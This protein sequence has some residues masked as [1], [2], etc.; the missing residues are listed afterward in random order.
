MSIHL[1]FRAVAGGEIRDDHAWLAEFMWA[2]WKVHAEEYAAGV[3]DSIDKA[4]DS[5]NEL[6]TAAE[7]L[8]VEG[9]EPWRLP[10][11]GGRPVRYGGGAERYDPPLMVMDAADVSRA[12]EFLA[13]VSF[14]ELWSVAGTR[15]GAGGE[16][17]ALFRQEYLQ[18]HESLRGFY[19]RAAAA[20]HVVVKAVW[21]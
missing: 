5:V 1:H 16:H 12:A 10:V 15:L 6:Y 11:Y 2:A 21:A 17:E 9:D 18:Y 3:T 4:W 8:G 13:E 19:G 14:D 20:G 7:G